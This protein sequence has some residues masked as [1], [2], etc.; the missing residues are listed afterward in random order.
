MGHN[1]AIIDI[2]EFR[3][4]F[5]SGRPARLS[6]HVAGQPIDWLLPVTLDRFQKAPT[7]LGPLDQEH[8]ERARVE[9]GFLRQHLLKGA[10]E[11]TCALCS[12]ALP[13]ELLVAGHIKPRSYCSR[14]ERLDY[15]H[16]AFLVCMLGCDAL[17]EKGFVTV[18]CG[19]TIRTA[20]SA[21]AG[22]KTLSST[23]QMLE[24]KRCAAWKNGTAEYF[25]WHA[26]R[27]FLGA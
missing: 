27:Q 4:L 22:S 7:F 17:Y 10:E 1:L 8:T 19:G 14:K 9:Q 15:E 25:A 11:A 23:L 18:L 5:V 3:K 16:I 2:R 21:A 6:D 13:D 12:K 26:E 24:G 20:S